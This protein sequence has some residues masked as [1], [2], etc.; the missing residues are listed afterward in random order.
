[1]PDYYSLF[2]VHY[3]LLS[4]VFSLYIMGENQPSAESIIFPNPA[5]DVIHQGV[6]YVMIITK[7]RKAAFKVI[8]I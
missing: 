2:S 1:M 6:Y 8:K 7:D 5:N 4:I 3:S